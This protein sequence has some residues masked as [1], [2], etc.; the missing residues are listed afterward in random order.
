MISPWPVRWR[1]PGCRK[2][3]FQT[4][5]A[6]EPGADEAQWNAWGALTETNRRMERI[7]AAGSPQRL[8]EEAK[9]TLAARLGEYFDALLSRAALPVGQ[10]QPFSGRAVISPGVGLRPDQVG[11][12]DALFTTLVEP[13][14]QDTEWV[15]INRAPTLAPTNLIAFHPLRVPGSTIRLHPLAC[16]ALNADFDGDQV[17]VFV[18]FSPAAQREAGE[19]LSLEAHLRRD[20]T[21]IDENGLL[22]PPPDVLWGLAFHSLSS[23]GRQEI[24][25]LAA[26]RGR[27]ARADAHPAKP[28]AQPAKTPVRAGCTCS[29]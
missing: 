27:I 23:A 18:P 28:G 2:G 13:R 6:P 20:P 7:I 21:L 22:I 15:L 17:A 26:N 9:K 4:T 5:A 29:A 24:D 16:K 19:R 14:S 12:P 3:R 8:V 1:T 10:L 25:A 11:L